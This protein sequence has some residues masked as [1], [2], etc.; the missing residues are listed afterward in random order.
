VWSKKTKARKKL[1]K[2]VDMDAP[3][4]KVFIPEVDSKNLNSETVKLEKA[5]NDYSEKL[6]KL[7]K[8]RET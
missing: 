8:L 7:R 2:H 4:T 5:V 1:I 3:K 6:S